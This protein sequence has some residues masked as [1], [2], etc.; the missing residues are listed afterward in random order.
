LGCE[1]MNFVKRNFAIAFSMLRAPSKTLEEVRLEKAVRAFTFL[2]TIGLVTAFLTPLQIF[3]GFEDV[4]GLHAGG[5]AEFL[6]KDISAMYRLGVEWRP[7]LIEIL[8]VFILLLSTGYLHFIFKVAGGKGTIKDTFKIIA[9]GDAP[10]LLFGW[11]PYFATIAALWAALIQLFIGPITLHKISWAKT[12]II[13]SFLV[14]LG[15]IE[16]AL[17]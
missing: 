17:T 2:L 4:N 11:I 5:Q 12:S 1:K 13:F 7:F 15:L 10:G 6:A 14:G 16:I 9:Y 3:L 8:Y